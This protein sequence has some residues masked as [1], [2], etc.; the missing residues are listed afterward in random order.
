MTARIR[1]IERNPQAVWRAIRTFGTQEKMAEELRVDQTTV[2]GWGSGDRPV[3]WQN[4]VKIEAGT[5][6]IAAS[7]RDP[8]LIVTCEELLPGWDWDAVLQLAILR[9]AKGVA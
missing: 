5:R 4:C 7:K 3:S 6:R 2:S 1:R 8:S 9:A